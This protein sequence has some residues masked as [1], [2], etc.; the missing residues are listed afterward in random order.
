MYKNIYEG[1]KTISSI[2]KDVGYSIRSLADIGT[3]HPNKV[4]RAKAKEILNKEEKT[5]LKF[6]QEYKDLLKLYL[7]SWIA[8]DFSFLKKTDVITNK[9][10]KLK[11][12]I[13]KF[14]A[15]KD[16]FDLMIVTKHESENGGNHDSVIDFFFEKGKEYE[17]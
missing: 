16:I 1:T 11:N 8:W 10:T 2:F 17:L 7:K 13:E 6:S 4:I 9:I 12:E 14:P 3:Q 5:I 15:Y